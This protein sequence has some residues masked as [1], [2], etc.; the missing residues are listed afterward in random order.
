MLK[1]ARVALIAGIIFIAS[2]CATKQNPDPLEGYNRA[3][4]SFNSY[5]YEYAIGPVVDVYD[6][7]LPDDAQH[8]VG[9]FFNNSFEI[10]HVVN[11]ILQ[12]QWAEAGKDAT[13]LVLNTIFGV[14]GLF[15]VAA[16]IG[17]P[18]HQQNFGLTMAK[19]GWEESAYFV[20]P[21]AGP[22]T[23]RD[24]VGVIPDIY[25]NPWT[26]ASSTIF[27]FYANPDYIS[28]GLSWGLFGL[29][30]V[31]QAAI[32]LP[33]MNGLTQY[34]IDPYIAVRNAY[35]QFKRIQ[36]QGVKVGKYASEPN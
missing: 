30:S 4:F 33:Q 25:L 1:T 20:W 5:A 36:I 31:N 14:F 12:W 19:W 16:S 3:M 7:V 21:L 27:L 8:G 13:R 32:Y 10:S 34:A 26:Y 17:L 6:F 2:G 18:P 15:D 24:T 9:N 11:D 29:Y 23:I 22:S 28:Q 35:L